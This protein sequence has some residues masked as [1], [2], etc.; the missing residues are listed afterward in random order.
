MPR[1]DNRP[2]SASCAAATARERQSFATETHLTK[3]G[4]PKCVPHLRNSHKSSILQRINSS[5]HSSP[6][7]PL[8][9]KACALFLLI[10]AAAASH[11]QQNPVIRT[12]TRIVLVDAIVTRKNGAYINDLTQK[13]FHVFEDN[14]EQVIKGFSLE[15]ASKA[16]EPRA[17]VLLFDKTSMEVRDQI[18]AREA[19]AR[20]IDAEIGPNRRMAVVV[21]DGSL[22][23]LETFTDNAGRLKDALPA[24]QSSVVKADNSPTPGRRSGGGEDASTTS[25]AADLGA[26]NMIR[27]VADLGKSLGVLPGRKIVVLFSGGVRSSSDQRSA[28]KDAIEACNRSGVAVY[29]VDT[30]PVFVQ[31]ELAPTPAGLPADRHPRGRSGGQPEG[32]TDNFGVA[33]NSGTGSQQIAFALATGTGGFLISNVNDLL[34][35]LQRIAAEQDEYYALTFTPPESKEGTCHTLRVKVDRSGATVRSRTSYCTSKSQDLLAGTTA[36]KTLERRASEAQPGNIAASLQL[37]Y[38]YIS[39]SVA[40]VHVAMEIPAG[41][42]KFQN[43]KAKPHAEIG[44]VAIASA[45]DGSVQARFSDA[46]NLN[47]ENQT[48]FESRKQQTIHYEKEFKIAP[49][50]YTFTVAFGQ[51]EASFGK[52]EAPLAIDPW[53]GELALSGLVLSKQTRPSGGLGLTLIAEDHTPLVADGIQ[54]VPSGSSQ[55]SPSEPAFFYFE[56]YGPDAA[57]ARI[58]AR[59]LDRKTGDQKW[60]SGLR[61][62]PVSNNKSS[63]VSAGSPLPLNGL[64]SGSYQLEVTASDG[65][66]KPVQRTTDFEIR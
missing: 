4:P 20:F 33:P 23:V 65:A 49:G 36:G 52:I 45:A 63:V 46:I 11:A 6:P 38:F 17:L 14:K 28:V 62:L 29:P 43:E 32:D 1:R 50:H 64:P 22:R 66:A 59:I 13:D 41:W 21:Y 55:F 60:D 12:E 39:P 9:A 53:S 40:R 47:F 24:P 2:S 26:R 37:A 61:K 10:T 16:A 3:I 48:Q 42:L 18:E 5:P 31:T 27:A 7:R 19:A 57:A 51:G 25:A 30:R 44:I 58:R 56:I 35:G 15:T 34:A 8:R 54:V